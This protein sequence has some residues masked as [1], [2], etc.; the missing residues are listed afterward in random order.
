MTPPPALLVLEDGSAFRGTSFGAPGESF[1]E[2][3]FNTGMAGYQEIL[4]DP[5]YAG[6]LV[7][8]TSPQQGNYGVNGDD[9]ESGRIQVAGFAVREAA[10]RPCSWRAEGDLGSAL[11]AADVVAIEGID[12][13]RLTLRLREAGAM[14][15]GV[16]TVDLDPASLL[17]R[18]LASDRMEGAELA[19]GVT[20]SEAY[21]AADVVGLTPAAREDGGDRYE[22]DGGN[23]SYQRAEGQ[24]CA[25]EGQA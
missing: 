5:S 25:R 13:R 15:A 19:S 18:V 23:T 10:R 6:Q 11:A 7:T 12:T 8:M 1:G 21:D 2:A 17:E 16:S 4:T 20:T 9:P 24:E 3:V 22:R 14:R